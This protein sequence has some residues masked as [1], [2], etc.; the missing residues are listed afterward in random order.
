VNT[1]GTVVD[2]TDPAGLASALT[3]RWLTCNR[4]G[5]FGQPALGVEFPGDG[6][7]Y[8]LEEDANGNLARGPGGTFEIVATSS[9]GC[10]DP[11]LPPSSGSCGPEPLSLM[12]GGTATQVV[13]TE[14]PRVLFFAVGTGTPNNSSVFGNIYAI[15][16]P[17]K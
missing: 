17:M 1:S 7:W 6:T 3:G 2:R 12:I 9:L 13:V 4:P 16:F 14:N 15:M 11:N 8:A 10:R 5:P